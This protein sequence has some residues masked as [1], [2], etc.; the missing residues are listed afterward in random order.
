ME[1]A[2]P[3]KPLTNRP[4]P[5]H[6]LPLSLQDDILMFQ[7]HHD[8]S[9][10]EAWTRFKYLLQNVLHHSLDLL[11][12]L[13]LFY[14]RIDYETQKRINYVTDG[15]FWGYD[16]RNAWETFETRSRF[17]SGIWDPKK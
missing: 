4:N 10:P 7:Q 12:L 8:E 17:Q 5:L 15:E 1:N 11:P 16:V 2:Y 6:N 9:F 3:Q 13:Q 14:T